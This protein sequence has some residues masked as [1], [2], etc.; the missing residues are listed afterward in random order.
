MLAA[1][2]GRTRS[3]PRAQRSPLTS[4]GLGNICVRHRSLPKRNERGGG[5]WGR[6]PAVAAS[7]TLLPLET[8]R[9]TVKRNT[10]F[11][12]PAA[13]I[14]TSLRRGGP[15]RC[16]HPH[17][18]SRLPRGSSLPTESWDG[19]WAVAS[20]RPRPMS[21]GMQGRLGARLREARTLLRCVSCLVK[22]RSAS[23]QTPLYLAGHRQRQRPPC[24]SSGKRDFLFALLA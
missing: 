22:Q 16:R 7:A 14:F 13:C 6:R 23:P 2:W 3:L 12:P 9:V 10:S 21:R 11:P 8:L 17:S 18:L 5:R 15:L 24:R 1:A 19:P 20:R 4:G